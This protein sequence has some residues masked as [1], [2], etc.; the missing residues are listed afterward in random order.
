MQTGAIWTRDGRRCA[1]LAQE[2]L[3]GES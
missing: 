3:I 1:S 2:A